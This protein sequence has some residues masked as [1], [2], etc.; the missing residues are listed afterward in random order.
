MEL[1]ENVSAGQ[2]LDSVEKLRAAIENETV[3]F[4]NTPICITISIGMAHSPAGSVHCLEDMI[5]Q[6][7]LALYEAKNGGRN[8]ACLYGGAVASS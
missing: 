7:D 5:L 1:L 3:F 2:M 6:A 4:H 8:R